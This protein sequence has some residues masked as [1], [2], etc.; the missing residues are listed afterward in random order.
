MN[1]GDDVL[2]LRANVGGVARVVM[3]VGLGSGCCTCSFVLALVCFVSG[4]L[5]LH[6]LSVTDGR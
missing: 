5:Q 1:G 2:S 4:S 6:R 3:G